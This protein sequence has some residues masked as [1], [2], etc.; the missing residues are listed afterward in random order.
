MKKQLTL[1]F[2]LLC[3]TFMFAQKAKVK[4]GSF[5]NLKGITE[6][7]VTFDYTDVQIP[8]YKSEEE[9]LKDKME[10]RDK[11]EPGTGEVFKKS[12]FDDR[13]AKYEPKFIESFNKRGAI[14]I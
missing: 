1:L 13:A 4:D 9:F 5:K 3:T 14:K 10:K 12:W 8:K 7:N 11:K 2:V 6:F